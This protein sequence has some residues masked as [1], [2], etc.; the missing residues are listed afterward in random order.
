M[1]KA[2]VY[3]GTITGKP[4]YGGEKEKRKSCRP[5]PLISM[6]RTHN[7]KVLLQKDLSSPIERLLSLKVRSFHSYQSHQ[8]YK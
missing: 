4:I 6:A 1:G 2:E 3:K 5:R 7:N 8:G